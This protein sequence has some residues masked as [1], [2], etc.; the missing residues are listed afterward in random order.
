M[1]LERVD[2]AVVG[3][4]PGLGETGLNLAVVV[5]ARQPFKDIGIGDFADGRGRAG[6]RIEMWRLEH[7]AEREVGARGKGR[8][9][10]GKRQHSRG[11][12]GLPQFHR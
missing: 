4:G 10:G 11:Q 6:G 1:Q 7:D 3:D 12:D 8:R 5:D 2:L 9:G